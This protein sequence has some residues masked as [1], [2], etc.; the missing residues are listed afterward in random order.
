VSEPAGGAHSDQAA[1]AEAL[2]E[3]LQE[4]LQALRA[5]PLERLLAERYEKYRRIGT[6]YE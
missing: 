1:T 4:E 3:A 2:R 6:F 5:L